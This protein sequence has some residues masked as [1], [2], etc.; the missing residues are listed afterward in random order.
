[1]R[2]TVELPDDLFRKAK[3]QAALQ[4]KALKDVVAD[5]LR[6]VL[7]SGI[8]GSG[9]SVPRRTQFPLIRSKDPTRKVTP[10][11][12]RAAEEHLI[13]EEAALHGRATGH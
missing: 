6:L 9:A 5:G 12:V 10:D 13:D 3:A 4:G 1:M 11:M 8:E 2:T 7:Q